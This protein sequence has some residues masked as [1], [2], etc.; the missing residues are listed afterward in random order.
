MSDDKPCP[1]VEAVLDLWIRQ[2]KI[3]ST[4]K[5]ALLAEVTDDLRKMN[6]ETATRQAETD[7]LNAEEYETVAD[8]VAELKIERD[9]A[10]LQG[11]TLRDQLVIVQKQNADNLKMRGEYMKERDIA[12]R[13]AVELQKKV[14]QI[15]KS[16]CRECAGWGE[17]GLADGEVSCPTCGGSGDPLRPGVFAQKPKCGCVHI[18]TSQSCFLPCGH[19]GLHQADNAPFGDIRWTVVP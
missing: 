17:I 2:G 1:G 10:S 15:S 13:Q 12:L 3:D 4:H 14:G 5:D 16:T 19:E 7:A 6:S 11:E 9:A 18:G 8:R